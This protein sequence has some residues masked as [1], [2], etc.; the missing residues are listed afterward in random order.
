MAALYFLF[1]AAVVAWATLTIWKR[2]DALGGRV[3]FWSMV[4]IQVWTTTAAAEAAVP[5]LSAKILWSKI[6]YLGGVSAGPLLLVFTLLYTHRKYLLTR[7][8]VILLSITPILILL[9][10]WTNEFHN[11]IWAGYEPYFYLNSVL[12]VYRYGPMFWVHAAYAY[13]CSGIAAFILIQEYVRASP[14]YRRQYGAFILATL[15]PVAGSLLYLLGWNPMPGLD[16]AALSF[17]ATGVLI[18][19]GT[20]VYGLMELV[21]IARHTL[22]DVLEDGVIVI[23]LRNRIVDMNRA[24]LNMFEIKDAPIGQD[25]FM[26]FHQYPLLAATLL[27]KPPAPMEVTL[28]GDPSHHLDVRLTEVLGDG[29]Q[30]EGHIAVLRD[31]TDRKKIEAALEEKREQMEQMAITDDLTGL[32]NRR[33]LDKVIEREF[34]RCERYNVELSVAI[35]DIDDFKQINDGFG[36]PCGDEALR[37]VANAILNNTRSTDITARMGGDEFIIIFPHTTVDDAWMIMERLRRYLSEI[38]YVC[39]HMSLSISGGVMEWRKGISSVETIR[40]VDHLLYEAKR[41]GKN[42]IIKSSEFV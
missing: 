15:A 34:R 40:R 26:T 38:D 35:F 27:Q 3:L 41:L 7:R 17:A 1:A 29:G 16:L 5:S 32:Y 10:T 30:T 8:N 33:H 14:T 19:Y 11:L 21:P 42:R 12:Y 39:G 36:H 9:L 22:V 4:A 28:P 20:Q 25:V 24:V 2:R 13:T 6:Q 37:T 18:A 31:I 23:D